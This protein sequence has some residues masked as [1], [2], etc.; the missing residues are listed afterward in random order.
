LVSSGS[1]LMA[2]DSELQA[3]VLVSW[4]EAHGAHRGGA[5]EVRGKWRHGPV[6]LGVVLST[7]SAEDMGVLCRVMG[8]MK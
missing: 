1:E 4:W 7:G 8:A 3:V 6:Q 2:A 5:E